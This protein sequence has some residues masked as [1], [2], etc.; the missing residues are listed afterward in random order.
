M[1]RNKL[2]PVCECHEKFEKLISSAKSGKLLPPADKGLRDLEKFLKPYT[3]LELFDWLSVCDGVRMPASMGGAIY[4]IKGNEKES[5]HSIREVV[6]GYHHWPRK[7][8]I[9]IASDMASQFYCLVGSEYDD[10]TGTMPVAYVDAVRLDRVEFCVASS[11]DALFR[12]MIRGTHE[13]DYEWYMNKKAMLK[14][15]PK[16]KKLNRSLLP[17]ES[18]SV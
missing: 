7:D 4:G 1:R 8:L 16:L 10:E 15:D 9:P 14:A 13:K 11:L 3:P 6:E 17:W 12:G 5:I 2:R 18:D